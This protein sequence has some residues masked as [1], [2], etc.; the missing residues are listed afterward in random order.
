MKKRGFTLIELLVVIAIIGILAAILLPALARARE[1]ARRA[2]CANNLKQMGIVFKMYAGESK[3]E[4][5]PTPA[6]FR[7]DMGVAI[8][9]ST[10]LASGLP[11]TQWPTESGDPADYFYAYIPQIYPEY[12]TDGNVLICPSEAEPA[13]LSN[14]STGESI[15]GVPCREFDVDGYGASGQP[16]AD[17]SYYYLGFLLDRADS[18]DIDPALLPGIGDDL[19]P[20]QNAPVSLQLVGV[21]ATAADTFER[22]NNDVDMSDDATI[23]MDLSGFGNGGGNT[24]YRLREGIERFLITD[25]NNPAASA[26]AQSEIP[27]S[28]DLC[29][30]MVSAYNHVP[31][32][33]NVLFL[34]GHVQFFKYPGPHL[35][36]PAVA[37]AV[38]ALA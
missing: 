36:S 18:P 4:K 38:G 8:D 25:I 9:C 1:A 32:G 19:T 29:A 11:S 17:E 26:S 20:G 2:S 33:S 23:G 34:D 7:K 30:T 12:L 14:P 3:G 13:V 35:V 27:I 24:V 16:G 22:C 37:S 15:L 5:Y 21:L 10:G 28:A 6:G 31:G